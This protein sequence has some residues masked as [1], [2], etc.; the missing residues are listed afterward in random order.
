VTATSG[1]SDQHAEITRFLAASPDSADSA[2]VER[3]T[4]AG[5]RRL[6][7]YVVPARPVDSARLRTAISQALP[8]VAADVV[9][10]SSLPHLAGGAVDHARLLTLPVLDATVLA[11]AR[12]AAHDAGQ[13][14]EAVLA[15]QATAAPVAP[16]RAAPAADGDP[17]PSQLDGGAAPEGGPATLGALLAAAAQRRPAG[18]ALTLYGRDGTAT[19]RGYAD[20]WRDAERVCGGLRAAGLLAGQRIV[21]SAGEPASFLAGF[22]GAVLAGLV[23]IPAPPPETA[24]ALRATAAAAGAALAVTDL[25][26]AE[27]PGLASIDALRAGPA[28]TAVDSSPE[29]LVLGLLTSGSTG[30]PKIV[31]QTHRAVIANAA[32]ASAH[33]GFG[34]A[35]VSLNWFPLDHV[36]GLVMFH[37]RDV[38]LACRQVQAPTD[39]VLRDPLVWLDLIDRHRVT[40]TWAPNF[41]YQLV[42]A[43]VRGAE[44]P[45]W[46]LSCLTFILNGGEAVVAGQCL[47]FLAA[48]APFGLPATAM[49]PAWGMSETCSGVVYSAGFAPGSIDPATAQ[50]PVGHPIPGCSVRVVD[51]EGAVVGYGRPGALQVRGPMVTAGY[52]DDHA[53]TQAAI[54][55]D[56]W[57]H[58]GDRA[59]LGPD[60]LTIIGRDKDVIIVGGRNITAAE[61][62]AVVDAVAGVDPTW[63]VAFA[64]RPEGAT[65]DQLAVVFVP[66]PGEP[67]T[68]VTERVRRAVLRE[69]RVGPANVRA[70]GRDDVAKTSIGKPK[71]AQIR[72]RLF[73]TPAAG[74]SRPPVA[75]VVLVPT[76]VPPVPSPNP[77]GTP[78]LLVAESGPVADAL[79]SALR[80]RGRAVAVEPPG[81]ADARDRRRLR[82][83]LERAGEVV[84]VVPASVAG[85]DVATAAAARCAGLAGLLRMLGRAER[86]HRPGPLRVSVVTGSAADPVGQAVAAF[87]VSAAKDLPGLRLRV[88]EVAGA[89]PGELARR[90]AEEVGAAGPPVV[91]L[92]GPVRRIPAVVPVPLVPGGD[93]AVR[94]GGLYL[95]T[96][97]LGG[98]GAHVCGYLLRE[99]D[100]RLLVLGTTDLD[101]ADLDTTDSDPTDLDTAERAADPRAARLAELRAL[102]EVTYLPVDVADALAMAGAVRSFERDRGRPLDGVFHLAGELVR[103]PVLELSPAD[104]EDAGY[105][106]GRGALAVEAL[107]DDR[108][109]A[110]EVQFT[111]VH[112]LVAAPGLAA[113][114]AANR[115]QDTVAA[116]H[117]ER[118]RRSWSIAWS[119]WAGPGMSQDVAGGELA[120]AM[121]LATLDPPA[122]IA[123]LDLL[124]RARPGWYAVGLDTG[125]PRL[126][127]LAGGARPLERI[128]VRLCGA[129]HG[130]APAVTDAYGIPVPVHLVPAEEQTRPPAGD[131]AAA[132]IMATLAEIWA[133]LLVLDA[134]SA[135]DDF[136]DLGGHSLL[137]PRLQERVRRELGVQ[138]PAVAVF[139]YPTLR[140]L[141]V[142]LAAHGAGEP[143]GE[144]VAAT[145]GN[146]DPRAG[147]RR[148]ASR[149]TPPG[150]G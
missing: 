142:A 118:G 82:S 16:V 24:D 128:E 44:K 87:A 81:N 111:S 7:A 23:T 149:R 25:P 94:A 52:L 116:L 35:E 1:A 133:E 51:A 95:V 93:S 45:A 131:G 30:R 34:S 124:L 71:R 135:E 55:R 68:E 72:D 17:R 12:R 100:A 119:R 26:G 97:G 91:D 115:L 22:W 61:V 79:A 112:G 86:P 146:A 92:A 32:A 59:V 108:P 114:A 67:A 13:V 147:L 110:I 80:D 60:G 2:V 19:T 65:T 37:L 148:Q 109:E 11:H 42:T 74:P 134:V 138:L 104:L 143:G 39:L 15:P 122:A 18:D 103:R 63:S 47:D 28:S 129:A 48:L 69:L 70:V 113:Y 123:A 56:G 88:I 83:E 139:E 73:G 99:F 84:F 125:S 53:A 49:H 144:P 96:G 57:L 145:L 85:E 117:R 5:E 33:N 10:V 40:V 140:E 3:V 75:E 150:D 8:Q 50:V 98:V 76:L 141:A 132:A 4:E 77:A 21:L 38:W 54:D 126:A 31:G 101:T 14:L 6:V 121:G 9:L 78:V 90:T 43:A 36:G 106:K 29:D 120:S 105:A 58:T 137:V 107:L 64:V 127:E 89:A 27:G 102:G 136:F 41:A 130:P 46:D 20:L 62:E 66:L